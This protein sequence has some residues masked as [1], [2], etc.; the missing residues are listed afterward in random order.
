MS[1]N[2]LQPGRHPRPE[3]QGCPY[4]P[5]R[6][7]KVTVPSSGSRVTGSGVGYRVL[8]LPEGTSKRGSGCHF[9]RATSNGPVRRK[10][11]RMRTNAR[12]SGCPWIVNSADR[13]VQFGARSSDVVG[14]ASGPPEHQKT[15]HLASQVCRM[16]YDARCLGLLR[17]PVAVQSSRSR[18]G[19]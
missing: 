11:S 4:D 3:Q 15:I 10:G 2:H 5:T 6:V 1:K 14:V 12:V 16:P 9:P 13:V 17:L 7:V 19:W 8:R 18:R